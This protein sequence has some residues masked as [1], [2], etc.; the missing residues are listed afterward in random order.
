MLSSVPLGIVTGSGFF[1]AGAGLTS[2]LEAANGASAFLVGAGADDGA[3]V[4]AELFGFAAGFGAGAGS[5]VVAGAGVDGSLGV[6]VLVAS[7]G[8]VFSGSSAGLGAHA[9]KARTVD[10]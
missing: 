4:V 5:G 8:A 6:A 1:G 3:L 10:R 7:G 2:L 9:L